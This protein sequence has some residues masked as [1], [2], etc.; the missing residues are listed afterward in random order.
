MKDGKT[1]NAQSIPTSTV[2]FVPSSRGGTLTRLLKENEPRLSEMTGF[3]VRYMEAGGTKLSQLFSTDTARGEHCHRVDCQPCNRVDENRQLCR[4]QN[5][6][7]E[8][9]CNICNPPGKTSQKEGKTGPRSGIY[10]GETSRSLYE[11]ANEHFNDAMGFTEK[12]H[13]VK[14]W[15]SCHEQEE[16]VPDFTI[17]I[18]GHLKTA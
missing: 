3:R 13:M 10:I 8:S 4:K 14:H 18:L 11:R 17:N 6:V 9:S 15:M 1:N 2:M 5:I 12:S 7:Y 16:T